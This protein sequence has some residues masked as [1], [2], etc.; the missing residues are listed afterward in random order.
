[1]TFFSG[2]HDDYHSPRDISAKADL[3]KM[4]AILNLTNNCLYEFLDSE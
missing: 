1:M 2:F 3:E 4:A